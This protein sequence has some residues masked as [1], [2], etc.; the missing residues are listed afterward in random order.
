MPIKGTSEFLTACHFIKTQ[1][2]ADDNSA[3]EDFWVFNPPDNE[4]F[5]EYLKVIILI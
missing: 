4:P 5:E 1:M 3:P 2:K